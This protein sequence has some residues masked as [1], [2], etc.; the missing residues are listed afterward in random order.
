MLDKV[1]ILYQGFY[2]VNFFSVTTRVT[3]VIIKFLSY[4]FAWFWQAVRVYAHLLKISKIVLR[5]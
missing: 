3:C 5:F 1:L 4:L 2:T